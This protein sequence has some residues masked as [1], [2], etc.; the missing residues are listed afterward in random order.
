MVEGNNGGHLGLPSA[1][2]KRLDPAGIVVVA[3][4]LGVPGL[5]YAGVQ[6]MI[7][8]GVA[9]VLAVLYFGWRCLDQWIGLLRDRTKQDREALKVLSGLVSQTMRR[10]RPPS[11]RSLTKPS[12]GP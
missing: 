7:A 10:R 9:C 1:A 12:N 3:L 2:W 5:I 4:F 6:P 8:A 11:N